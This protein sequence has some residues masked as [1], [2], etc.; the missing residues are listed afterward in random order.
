MHRVHY[1]V[2]NAAWVKTY[3]ETPKLLIPS[4]VPTSGCSFY[5]LEV[6]LSIILSQRMT[7]GR[8]HPTPQHPRPPWNT[9]AFPLGLG[10]LVLTPA[11]S[12]PSWVSWNHHLRPDRLIFQM[13]ERTDEQFFNLVDCH[14]QKNNFIPSSAHTRT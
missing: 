8:G 9:L 12:L 14:P 11:L 10:N 7:R 4:L 2:V 1:A 6:L 5:F 3:A 13:K